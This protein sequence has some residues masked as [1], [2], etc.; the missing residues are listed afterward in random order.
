MQGN[1][2]LLDVIA[3]LHYVS[4]NI[5]AFGGDPDRVTLMGQGHGA[6]LV[7]LLMVSPVSA[8]MFMHKLMYC[9][10]ALNFTAVAVV[11]IKQT[12]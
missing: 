6:A 1:V 12:S 3:A 2:A 11:A 7:N 10:H 8:G 9:K 5:R 4:Q